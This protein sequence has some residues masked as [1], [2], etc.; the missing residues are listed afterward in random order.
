[1][2]LQRRRDVEFETRYQPAIMSDGH[3]VEI[4]ANIGKASEAARAVEAAPRGGPA[5]TEFLFLER[6]TAP[7]EEE[8]FA[9]YR[10]MTTALSGLPLIIRTLDI[11]GDKVVLIS[12]F[13]TRT[14]HSSNAQRATLLRHPGCSSRNCAPF[15][16]LG[17]GPLKIMF[18]MISS[19]ED[20]Q[21]R[22]KSLSKSA[23]SLYSQSK[24]AS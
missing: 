8:Q 7:T 19:L 2:D 24:S 5:R 14:I 4:V 10:T 20:L 15:T 17:P 9:A 21:R 18:P 3:R 1:M 13:P 23:R 12:P 11:G 22:K 16:R 6:E